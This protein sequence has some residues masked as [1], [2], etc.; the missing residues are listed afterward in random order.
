MR[1]HVSFPEATIRLLSHDIGLPF[2]KHSSSFKNNPKK[3]RD[4]KISIQIQGRRL[5]VH[6][7]HFKKVRP[8]FKKLNTSYIE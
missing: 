4:K 6:V 8:L 7:N 5:E 2:K 3:N 1:H